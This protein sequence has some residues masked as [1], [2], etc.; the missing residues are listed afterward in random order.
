M[1]NLETIDH[2]AL[3]VRNISVVEKFGPLKIHRDG[4][5]FIYI[6]DNQGNTVEIIKK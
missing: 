3:E 5:N 2:I 1:K 6:E 4:V